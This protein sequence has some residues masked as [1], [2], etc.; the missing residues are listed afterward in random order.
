MDQKIILRFRNSSKAGTSQEIPLGKLPN[1]AIGRD[2]N[3]E[4]A[5][6]PDK[7][8]LVS[9]AHSKISI[10]G[11]NFWIGDL[12]SR[13]GTYVN[14]QRV[15][16]RVKLMPGDI[17]QLGPGGPEFEFTLDPL[18]VSMVHAA[19]LARSAHAFSARPR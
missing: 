19:N 17:V 2:P 15:S 14:T 6:D 3:C 7:G 11:D 1:I 12:G 16:G 18:P 13:N 5:F 8:D 4:V 10:E 9:R